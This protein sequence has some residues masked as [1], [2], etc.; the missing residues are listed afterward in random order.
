[1]NDDFETPLCPWLDT[2]SGFSKNNTWQ[3]TELEKEMKPIQKIEQLEKELAELK[4]ELLAPEKPMFPRVSRKCFTPDF[5]Y[6]G[7]IIAYLWTSAEN[8]KNLNKANLAMPQEEALLVGKHLYSNIWFTR[9]ALEFADGYNFAEGS[10]NCYVGYSTHS[11]EWVATTSRYYETSNI[12]MHPWAAE[13]FINWL[14]KYKPEGW[15][16]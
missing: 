3:E 1:M 4:K 8:V 10:E 14:N 15:D 16:K 2:H 6:T 5:N 11:K 9:K 7:K 12:Y 13:K